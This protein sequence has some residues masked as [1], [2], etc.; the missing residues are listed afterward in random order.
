MLH[1]EPLIQHSKQYEIILSDPTLVSDRTNKVKYGQIGISCVNSEG[2]EGSVSSPASIIIV[3][4][5]PPPPQV[6]ED[7]PNTYASIPNYYGKSS[8]ALRWPKS[9]MDV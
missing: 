2:G 3:F 1:S 8:Y 4:R 5:E 7:S 6:S 9:A